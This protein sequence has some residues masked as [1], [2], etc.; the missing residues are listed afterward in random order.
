MKRFDKLFADISRIER[1]EIE[2]IITQ[3]ETNGA[4]LC[5][6]DVRMLVSMSSEERYKFLQ[7]YQRN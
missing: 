6:A 7:M 3:L 2:S 1:D 4:R 5:T